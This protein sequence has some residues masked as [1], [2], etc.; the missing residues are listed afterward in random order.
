MRG[1]LTRVREHHKANPTRKEQ[2]RLRAKISGISSQLDALGERIA[3]LPKAVSALPLYKQMERLETLR[4]EH[5]ESLAELSA[6]GS[7]VRERIVG[8]DTF[9]D[10]AS[11]YRSFLRE[12]ATIPERKQAM[13]KF[14]RKVEVSTESVK[15][16]YIVD[17]DHYHPS[18]RP[19]MSTACPFGA[20]LDRLLIFLGM[21]VRIL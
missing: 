12:G 3:E 8:L 14:I 2:E 18:V 9:Q 7:S 1:I 4:K 15:I 21:R 11:Y 16:H 17:E 13:Q 19:W 5:E 20:V 6:T 10:F